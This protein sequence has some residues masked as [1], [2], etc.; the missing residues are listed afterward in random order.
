[1]LVSEFEALGK[2]RREFFAVGHDDQNRFSLLMNFE[3]HVGNDFGRLLIEISGGFVAQQQLG[4]HDQRARQSDTLLFTAR[5]LRG[6]MIE[7]FS[8]TDLFKEFSSTPRWLA[9][10]VDETIVGVNTFSM[11]EHCGNRQWSW[12]TNP[13]C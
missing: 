12:N 3:Q 5:Q 10:V 11:T 6:T 1:M 4:F 9:V 13:I 8:E 7:A 2:P